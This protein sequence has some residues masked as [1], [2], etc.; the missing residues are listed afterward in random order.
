MGRYVVRRLLQMIPVFIG[1]TFI[2]FMMMYALPGDP[3]RALWGER[4][5][6]EAQ[7]AAMKED[8]G[9]D[10][11]ILKQY[12]DYLT[13]LVQ[14]DFGTQIASRREV[15]DV[16]ADALPA[17]V[18]LTVLAFLI[19][20]CLG[21]AMGLLAG[22]R[23]GGKTDRVVLFLTLLLTSVP[24]FVI[25]YLY[26]T[27]FGVQ[28]GWVKPNVQDSEAWGQLL[29]PAVVLASLSLAYVARL[30]RTSIAENKRADYMRTARAKGLSPTRAVRVHLLR[31]S[32]IPV[33]TFLGVDLGNLFAGAIVT[34]GIFNIHGIGQA[35]YNALNAREGATVVGIVSFI[36][37]IYLLV[38]LIVDLLYAVLDPRIRYA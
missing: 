37:L 32:L 20:V 28:W 26:Q 18:R 31:N 34:E 19:T 10:Q 14:G 38:T 8:L 25:G 27:Y 5:P 2:I 9:L 11:P 1:A 23:A 13:G 22:L 15:I 29:L 16:I 36:I 7:M 17:T 12:W 6:D 21:V 3:I 30:T 24:V 4:A 33:V 35:V